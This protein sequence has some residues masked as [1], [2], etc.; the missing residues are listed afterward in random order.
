[1]IDIFSDETRRD[2]YA[3]YARM[4]EHSPA[5]YMP[6][7]FDGWLIFDYE[8]VKRVLNDQAAF[9]SCVPAPRN[10]FIFQDPPSHTKMRALISRAFTPKML[11]DL[12]PQ[13]RGISRRLLDAVIE[14]GRMDLAVDYAV[15][16]PMRVIAGMIGIPPE[17]WLKYKDWSDM[18]LRLSYA[19]TGGQD[20]EESVRAFKQVTAEMSVYL[21]QMS[22]ERRRVPRND[23]LTGLLNAEA[24]GEHLTHEEIL[25]FLQLLLVG[26]QET[27]A[28]LINNA[29]LCLTE[30]PQQ[31][32]RLQNEPGLL[33]SAIEE[34]LR[35]R[36]PLQWVMR[37]P[38]KDVELHG[39]LIPAGKLVLPMIGSANRDPKQF[40]NAESFEITR[41]P[42]PHVAFGHGIHACLG[43]ALARME[44]RVALP[45]LMGRLK[46]LKVESPRSWTPRKALH[47]HGPASLP[48]QFTP[49]EAV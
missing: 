20:A 11:A 49:A 15:P 29:I 9:S 35:Y 33:T 22:E 5:F 3:V 23:L 28:N 14:R 27:T 34:V 47:V 25:G 17:D 44:A 18:I 13:I 37:T 45:D 7:P 31:L 32:S 16:L 43:A 4:R 19:R 42:N 38:R 39:K 46:N 21:Q 41:N 12:E 8:G 48:V 2:P 24:D 10:W 36:A 40:A 30:N 6:P 26:G 1:M